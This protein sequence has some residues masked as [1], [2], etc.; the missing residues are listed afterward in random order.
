M[1]SDTELPAQSNSAEPVNTEN[2]ESSVC[3]GAAQ[4]LSGIVN[5]RNF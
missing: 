1:P 3:D 4:K 2:Y 5:S